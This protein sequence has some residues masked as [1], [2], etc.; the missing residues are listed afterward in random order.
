[1]TVN[2]YSQLRSNGESSRQARVIRRVEKK[3]N[4][5]GTCKD[6][7]RFDDDIY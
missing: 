5:I 7:A 1:M 6:G 2:T 4:D 3:G